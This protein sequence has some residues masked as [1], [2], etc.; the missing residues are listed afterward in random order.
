MRV[1]VTLWQLYDANATAMWRY[2]RRLEMAEN[3]VYRY[4][5][6]E[7]QLAPAGTT[8][9]PRTQAGTA[10]PALSLTSMAPWRTLTGSSSGHGGTITSILNNKP[11]TIGCDPTGDLVEM[12]GGPSTGGMA[13]VAIY[14]SVLSSSQVACALGR[15]V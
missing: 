5:T 8:L 1:A 6:V 4:P 7:S 12:T 13:E 10:R 9:S 2:T 3:Y 15:P 11:V 14:G